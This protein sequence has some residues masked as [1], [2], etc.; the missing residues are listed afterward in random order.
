M[1]VLEQHPD[2]SGLKRIKLIPEDVRI[3]LN[4][5]FLKCSNGVFFD[6]GEQ[7]FDIVVFS[8][9][10]D[11]QCLDYVLN[12]LKGKKVLIIVHHFFDMNCGYDE[13]N[14]GM[15]TF[16]YESSLY[17]KLY[18]NGVQIC[19]L[20]FPCD[21]N[22]SKI[23]THKSFFQ[24]IFGSLKLHEPVHTFP[25]GEMG[26]YAYIKKEQLH[27]VSQYP[28]I[29]YYGKQYESFE[30]AIKKLETICDER[31]LKVAVWAGM[32]S[33]TEILKE[34]EK[35]M[36]DLCICGDVLLRNKSERSSEMLNYL[37]NMSVNV[38]CIS[39][40]QSE[41]FALKDLA[42]E[43]EPTTDAQMIVLED[44]TLWK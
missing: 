35:Q 1:T 10:L 8:V 17:K 6:L 20:H 12:Q 40:Y 24:N 34:I 18:N 42:K 37:E 32:I 5:N 16:F 43:L 39:H 19:V 26:Y 27:S 4:Y 31:P 22:S 33:S 3:L 21:I 11:Q 14:P 36:Y 13:E 41:L 25:F 2:V 23:N 38:F 30:E 15:D 29:I 9:F 44:R 28:K 7:H